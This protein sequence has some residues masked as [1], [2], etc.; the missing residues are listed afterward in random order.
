MYFPFNL[1]AA[2][3]EDGKDTPRGFPKAPL[4]KQTLPP[5]NSISESLF[6][7]ETTNTGNYRQLSVLFMTFGQ[8]LDHDMVATPHASCTI[9][10]GGG[11]YG[12]LR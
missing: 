5:P 2:Q 9:I 12:G 6:H 1:S 8:F 4:F 3:Y 10:P 7:V 11:I